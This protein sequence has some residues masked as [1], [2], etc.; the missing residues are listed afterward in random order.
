MWISNE[1]PYSHLPE[2]IMWISN[3]PSYSH[4]CGLVMNPQEVC[5]LIINP[6]LQRYSG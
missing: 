5:E 1:P 2:V 3:E 6:T 4:L